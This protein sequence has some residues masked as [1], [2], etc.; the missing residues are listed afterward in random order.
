MLR[1]ALRPDGGLRP[2]P[3]ELVRL[4]AVAR[5]LIV[6]MS[7]R[8]APAEREDLGPDGADAVAGILADL[9]EEEPELWLHLRRT[10]DA[11][12]RP[13]L[14]GVAPGVPPSRRREATRYDIDDWTRLNPDPPSAGK[15]RRRG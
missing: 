12:L 7:G 15:P 9:R 14:A 11:V 3:V 2:D 13:S 5:G 1:D 10:I 6:G 4:G 8:D